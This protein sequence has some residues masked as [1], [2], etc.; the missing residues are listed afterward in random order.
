[1][2]RDMLYIQDGNESFKNGLINLEKMVLF[3]KILGRIYN[4]RDSPYSF[5]KVQF[6]QNYILNYDIL[7]EEELER[8][9]K[10]CE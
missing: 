2:M 4:T 9:S 5:V 7:S 1:M 6:L 3:A 10:L 8:K